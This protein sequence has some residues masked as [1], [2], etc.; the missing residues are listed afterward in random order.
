MKKLILF[1]SIL[2]L[3]ASCASTPGTS[4]DSTSAPQAAETTLGVVGLDARLSTYDYPYSVKWFKGEVQG[5]SLEMAYMDESPTAEPRGVVLLLHGKN[6][7]GAYWERT[8][9]HL[10][11]QGWR[12]I[13][14]DQVGFGKSS[15]PTNIE[16]SFEMMATL[17][18]LLLDEV[19]VKSANVVGHSMGGMLATRFAL[20]YPES[21]EKLVMVNP[22][23]L[24]DWHQ[25][26]VPMISLQDW[27]SGESKRSLESIKTYM[28][29][30]Y[31]DGN[32]KPEYDSLLDI[33]GGWAV[34]PDR[35]LMG[36]VGALTSVMVFTQPVVHDF[37]KIQVPALLIIGQRDK[38]AIGKALAP[39]E[40]ASTLGNYPELGRAAA[41]AIPNASLVEIEAVGHVPQL[42]AWETY[43]GALDGFLAQ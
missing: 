43:I 20:T 29:N 41:A 17:T 39:P 5:E 26:G 4:D 21:T 6:F 7:S 31:F 22:I 34:G 32:W 10:L 12:V 19:G 15:K 2:G 38:T 18:K 35:E 33:Q 42:E 1:C 36:K 13:A 14:P 23:G 37:P 8:M 40:V 3:T 30:A 9:A 25:K 28:S 11:A 16:Y 27:E 24:E